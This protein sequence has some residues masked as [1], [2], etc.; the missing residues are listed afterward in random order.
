M[1]QVR[2][3]HDD[4]AAA[5]TGSPR[6]VRP[7]RGLPSGRAVIGGFLVALAAVGVFAAYTSVT[8]PPA[9]SYAVA[10]RD[11]QPG[12]QI[13]AGSV[14]LVPINLPDAQRQ[15]SYDQIDALIDATV[16]EP[17]VA[18]ELLQEGSLIATGAEVGT[19]TVSFPIEPARAVNATLKNGERVDILA[20]F[21]S[22]GESCTHLVAGDVPIVA[23][24]ESTSSLVGQPG[25]LTIT[26]QVETADA[27][28]AVAHAANAGTM[29]LVR[30]THAD[31][32]PA[33]RFCTPGAGGATGG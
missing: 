25:G 11:L 12:D 26:V 24:A 9:T 31:P 33:K 20:T 1:T 10:T 13:D 3:P 29:T 19:R 14:E 21:G 28:L 7:R 32:A 17:L 2:A 4:S 22:G 27:G 30:T 15:R 18:G 23:V 8:A 6:T 16:I 5:R